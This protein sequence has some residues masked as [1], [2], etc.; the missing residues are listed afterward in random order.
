MGMIKVRQQK[1]FITLG[2]VSR[3]IVAACKQSKNLE[4][5]QKAKVYE[6]WIFDEVIPTVHKHGAYMTPSVL[7]QAMEDPDFM[8]GLFQN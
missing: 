1:N 3:L 6:K 7:D 2:Y 4:I 8:I 5:Q